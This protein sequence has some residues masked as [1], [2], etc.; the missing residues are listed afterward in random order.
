MEQPLRSVL[1]TRGLITFTVGETHYA[2]PV[3]EVAG[4]LNADRLSALPG[5][6][7]P[8]AGVVA[9]RGGVVPVLDLGAALHAGESN[10]VDAY[11]IVLERGTD[12]FALLVRGMPRLVLSRDAQHR[13]QAAPDPE[14]EPDRPIVL[15]VY[16]IA[17]R[18]VLGLDYWSLMDSIAPPAAF[19]LSGIGGR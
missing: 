14:A 5:R 8:M 9:F 7:G 15:A 4:L 10:A 16:E 17:G 11:A 6:N 13:D 1:A 3:E 18:E 2:A 19:R 12:R